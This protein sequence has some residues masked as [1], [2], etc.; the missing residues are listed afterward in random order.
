[1]DN[2]PF[3]IFCILFVGYFFFIYL[4]Q[5]E[6]IKNLPKKRQGLT[7]EE[8]INHFKSKGYDGNIVT[9]FY[10]EIEQFLPEGFL[11]HPNDNLENDYFLHSEDIDDYFDKYFKRLYSEKPSIEFCENFHKIKKPEPTFEYFFEMLFYK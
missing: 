4:H 11:L 1:M 6:I 5:K 3:L 9:E 8:F 2:I 10:N 7:K